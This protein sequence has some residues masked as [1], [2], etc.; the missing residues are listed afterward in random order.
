MNGPHSSMLTR[1]VL[2]FGLLACLVAL[3]ALG[4][5]PIQSGSALAESNR[6]ADVPGEEP[7]E[8]EVKPDGGIPFRRRSTILSPT[9][10]ALPERLEEFDRFS[11]TPILLS[12]CAAVCDARNG[13]GGPLR[14]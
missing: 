12:T 9:I 8:E 4:I 3:T 14:L 13:F 6:E 11:K 7:G 2:Y 5:Q 10:E 1:R